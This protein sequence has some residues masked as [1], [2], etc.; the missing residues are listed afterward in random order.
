[1]YTIYSGE[2]VLHHP[3]SESKFDTQSESAILEEELNAHGTLTLALWNSRGLALRAPVT[4]YDDDGMRWRGRVLDIQGGLTGGKKSIVCEGA[5][6][7]LCDTILKPFAFRGTRADFF[8]AIITNH[9]NSLPQGDERRFTVGNVD[10]ADSIYRSSETAMS[11][12]EAITS[13]LIENPGGYVYLSGPN[14]DTINYTDDF[15]DVSNQAIHFGENIID[16][17]QTESAAEIV[18]ALDAYG[19]QVDEPQGEP[20]G[21]GL[22]FWD[23]DRLHLS[24]YVTL[25]AAIEKW[26]WIYGTAVFED[27]DTISALEAAAGA[28]VTN[29]FR[30]HIESLEVTA[31]DL[32]EKDPSIDKLNVGVY[33]HTICEPLNIDLLMLCVQKTTDLIK[34]IQ[35]RVSIGH[36]PVSLSGI[37]GGIT[38]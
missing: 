6:A 32:S 31:A 16:L 1:M 21:A 35:T 11:S 5:L 10:G 29:N 4:V 38:K 17:V 8:R 25:P 28:W 18:T 23:G 24:G 13:R 9:N 26:G 3:F 20:T 27:C 12:W 37:I 36:A 30:Q 19:A 2:S 14:L 7:A 22:V 34:G 33:V 15:S